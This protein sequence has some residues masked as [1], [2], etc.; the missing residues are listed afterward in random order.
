MGFVTGDTEMF[1]WSEPEKEFYR[2][3]CEKMDEHED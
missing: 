1:F 2:L 3:S